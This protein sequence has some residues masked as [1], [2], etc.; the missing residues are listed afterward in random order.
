MV[1]RVD[2]D[3]AL[4]PGNMAIGATGNPAYAYECARISGAELAALGINLNFAPCLDVNN[5]AANPVIGVRS[6]GEDP[7]LV[8][9]LGA[10]AIR[11]YQASG[12]SACAKHFPGHGD[13]ATDSHHE[14]PIVP[15]NAERM[16]ELELVPFRDAVTA[17][18]DAIM[19]AHVLF[20]ALEP[21]MVP[22][23]LSAQVL[24]GLLREQLGYNGVIVT[25]CLEMKAIADT[26]GVGPGA[27]MAVQAG[28]DLVLVSHRYDRQLEAL[29]AL[30][31]AVKSGEIMEARI[32]ESVRRILKIKH[33][34]SS[35]R[36]GLQAADIGND[37]HRAF[38]Q[39]VCDHAITL[40]HAADGV[41]P[42]RGDWPTL[43]VW[44]EVRTSSEVDEIIDQKLTLGGALNR[45]LNSMHELIIGVEPSDQEIADVLA[46]AR[47]CRQIVL[48]TYN[49]GFAEGQIRLIQALTKLKQDMYELERVQLS[50]IAVALRNPYDVQHFLAFDAYLA[51]YEN[52][53][54]MLRAAAKV[55]LGEWEPQGRLPV[56][57]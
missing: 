14:L 31:D 23:T 11:G 21:S 48:A 19:T 4:M 52:R 2:Q 36:P 45:G 49:A 34:R 5:N 8:A 40:V 7:Q 6:Y 56:Y 57:L 32:D 53:P 16:N 47:A 24:T 43:V 10:A 27:V 46:Q 9:E 22:A 54:A 33:A 35:A 17:G 38:A 37:R 15:H 20:P 29:H 51:C 18:V 13:T 3:V 30:Y 41:L 28:A 44:P 42:L 50:I 1:A 55:L 25:D 26:V 39:E 12:V